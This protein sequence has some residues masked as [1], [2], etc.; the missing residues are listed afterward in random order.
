MTTETHL[1]CIDIDDVDAQATTLISDLHDT[2]WIAKLDA[3]PRESYETIALRTAQRLIDIF[4]GAD[5]KIKADFGEYMVSMSAGNCLGEMLQHKVLPISE[6]WKEQVS[7]NP[8]FDFHTESHHARISFGEAK[9]NSHQNSYAKAASQVV[10]F[11]EEKKDK[12]D[13]IHLSHLA[14][15]QAVNSALANSRG[16]AIAFSLHSSDHTK[17]LENALNSSFVQQLLRLCDELYIIGVRT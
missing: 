1:F 13:L 17:I 7:G 5:G 8:G 16:L 2:S 4:R 9:Y 6:L 11:I 10:R 12:M 14:N 3:I 15:M